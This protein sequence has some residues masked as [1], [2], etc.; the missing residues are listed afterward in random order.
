[1]PQPTVGFLL[2]WA[3]LNALMNLTVPL[4]DL[5]WWT[6]LRPSPEMLIVTAAVAV[7]AAADRPRKPW[8]IAPATALVALL[9]AFQFADRLVPAYFNRSFNLY[10]DS[11]YLPDLLRLL[12]SS[13][14]A[15]LFATGVAAAAAG[16]A[17]ICLGIT[18]SLSRLHR[19]L[20]VRRQRREF[21]VGGVALAVVMWLLPAVSG[22][23]R[24][25]GLV[26]VTAVRLT[27]EINFIL[28]ADQQR[29]QLL[30][31]LGSRGA[32]QR[33]PIPRLSPHPD[34]FLI[35]V[36]SYGRTVFDDPAHRSAFA[37]ALS[38]FQHSLEQAGWLMASR[39][40]S[41][42]TYG[43]AS[44]LAHATV[45][46]GIHLNN[47]LR[48][49]L[50]VTSD[51][52]TLAEIFNAAGYRTVL[53]APG[54]TLPWPEGTFFGHVARYVAAD[55]GYRGPAFGWST[56]PDQ[57]ALD[58]I[59][60]KELRQHARPLFV[61]CILTSAHAP[62][63]RLPPFLADGPLTGDGS[64]YREKAAITFPVTWPDLN[65][66]AEAYIEALKYDLRVLTDF[67]TRLPTTDA[68]VVVTGDHQPNVRITGSDKAWSVPVH[69]IT[70]DARLVSAF[71]AR[72]YT[73]GLV[74]PP[75]RSDPGLET[76]HHDLLGVLS[77]ASPTEPH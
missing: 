45:A 36:E 49:N 40:L 25:N 67:I 63:N 41:S 71:A 2:A 12:R 15:K 34:V 24:R 39:F 8:L 32:G 22:D 26:P 13:V 50:A 46:T 47:Q 23:A 58:F 51:A 65:N 14:S 68:L 64:V 43:G 10:T 62:F 4:A 35:F 30:A 53:A 70:R 7:A 74:P 17:G 60:R 27:R 66:A 5:R 42:P 48:Y 16:L 20:S 11:R 73:R 37:P 76:L 54:V 29:R 33:P 61:E 72:G 75:D 6:L 57:Y 28:H 9:A 59:Y 38:R 1:M 31:E 56:M 21:W 55:F 3:F 19:F 69:V 52:R 77:Q 18:G 44:W